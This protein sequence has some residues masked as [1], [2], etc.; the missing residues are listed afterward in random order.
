MELRRHQRFPVH[1]HTVFSGPTLGKS[2]GTIVNLSEG[3]CRIQSDSQVYTGIQ[4]AL[5]LHLPGEDSPIS[6]EKAAVRWNRGREIGVG[7]ITVAPP[8]QERLSHLLTRLK[9]EN[10]I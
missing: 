5:G 1:F 10:K 3:G 4:V 9:K 8:Q 7:F 2:V 6:I